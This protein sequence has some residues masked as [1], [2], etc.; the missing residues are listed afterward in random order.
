MT[1]TSTRRASL[2]VIENP[3]FIL[4]KIDGA[5]SYEVRIEQECSITPLWTKTISS[6]DVTDS[7]YEFPYPANEQKLTMLAPY[8]LIAEAKNHIGETM[9]QF[10]TKVIFLEKNAQDAVKEIQDL[11]QNTVNNQLEQLFKKAKIALLNDCEPGTPWP[12]NDF[13]RT[14][15]II[16]ISFSE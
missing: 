10:Q 4:N 15:D 3:S 13:L 6:S 16:I 11:I 2:C 7:F 8:L 12:D 9:K 5:S 1:N 14:S